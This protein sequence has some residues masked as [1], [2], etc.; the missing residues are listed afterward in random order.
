MANHRYVPYLFKWTK[1]YPQCQGTVLLVR[2]NTVE[3]LKLALCLCSS[4]LRYHIPW[5]RSKTIT[6]IY[7][8]VC[9]A[10]ALSP[11]VLSM[12]PWTVVLVHSQKI[13]W[14]WDKEEMHLTLDSFMLQTEKGN[15]NPNFSTILLWLSPFSM[16]HKK[17]FFFL[18]VSFKLESGTTALRVVCEKKIYTWSI[19]SS[20]N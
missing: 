13:R 6:S 1:L 8:K 14:R 11:T 12:V 18:E 7:R 20:L 5:Y 2:E 9:N 10:K 4:V 3:V 15:E 16:C 19:I 17:C